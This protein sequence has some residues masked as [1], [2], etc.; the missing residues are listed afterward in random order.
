MHDNGRFLCQAVYD[1]FIYIL[2]RMCINVLHSGEKWLHFVYSLCPL[3]STTA[4]Q[5]LDCDSGLLKCRYLILVQDG[6]IIEFYIQLYV[7]IVYWAVQMLVICSKHENNVLICFSSF[8][9]ACFFCNRQKCLNFSRKTH[10]S[11]NEDCT[12]NI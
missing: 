3:P 8:C 7:Y 10:H 2:C 12:T 6:I 4:K 9:S 11:V 1:L 5:W